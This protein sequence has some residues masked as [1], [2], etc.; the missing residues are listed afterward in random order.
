MLL[1]HCARVLSAFSP[2]WCRCQ[3]SAGLLALWPGGLTPGSGPGTL[4][5]GVWTQRSR[6]RGPKPHPVRLLLLPPRHRL[7]DITTR[8]T[9]DRGDFRLLHYA[10]EVTYCVVG[11]RDRHTQH[12]E[13]VRPSQQHTGRERP[14]HSKYRERERPSHSTYRERERDRHTQHTER[15]RPSQ[16]HTG[17]ERPSHSTYRERE[18]ETAQ[19]HTERERP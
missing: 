4:D 16:Q 19:Q 18:R 3:P 2:C 6:P 11:K 5:R 1:E 8:K 9:L 10:G 15:E 17:R 14:S 13:R 7:A 12:T